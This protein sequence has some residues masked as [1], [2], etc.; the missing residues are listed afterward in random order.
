MIELD[1]VRV[2]GR[3]HPERLFGLLG[4]ETLAKTP[5]FTALSEQ[6]QA[7]LSAYRSSDWHAV[8]AILDGLGSHTEGFGLAHLHGLYR[9]RISELANAP[10]PADWDGVYE[11]RSK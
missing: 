9:D 1:L 3:D 10:P 11:A 6:H 5:E 7:M 4:D 2:V 8:L